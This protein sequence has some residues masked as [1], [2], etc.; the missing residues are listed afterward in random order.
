MAPSKSP[1]TSSRKPRLKC[2]MALSRASAKA[3]ATANKTLHASKLHPEPRFRSR[4]MDSPSEAFHS[5][6]PINQR[7][8]VP[9]RTEM[10]APRSAMLPLGRGLSLTVL[11]TQN[12]LKVGGGASALYELHF[13]GLDD[14]HHKNRGAIARWSQVRGVY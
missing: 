10:T 2:F 9:R 12:C 7:L 11:L 1:F 5:S 4:C 13:L 14:G 3:G 8:K 6:K